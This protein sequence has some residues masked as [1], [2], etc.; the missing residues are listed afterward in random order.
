MSIYGNCIFESANESPELEV[1]IKETYTTILES[2]DLTC[3]TEADTIKIKQS[4]DDF[5]EDA[6]GYLQKEFDDKDRNKKLSEGYMLAGLGLYIVGT[7]AAAAVPIGGIILLVGSI[8]T[9]IISIVHSVKFGK[10][11][12]KLKKLKRDLISA[13]S[14]VSNPKDK[15]KI[16]TIIE[17]IDVE[18]S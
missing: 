11:I 6:E 5:I 7:G 18:I 1:Y 13:R 2:I 16:N 10:N 15:E 14:N 3:I 8:V 17:K 4:M 9:S 12:D